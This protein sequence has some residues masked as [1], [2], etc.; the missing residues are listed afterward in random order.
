[1]GRKGRKD[2]KEERE[3]EVFVLAIGHSTQP[4]AHSTQHSDGVL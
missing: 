1:M 2:E 4:T 3:K